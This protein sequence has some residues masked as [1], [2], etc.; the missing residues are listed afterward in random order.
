MFP[1]YYLW[2]QPTRYVRD[3]ATPRPH[4][5]VTTFTNFAQ[6]THLLALYGSIMLYSSTMWIFWTIFSAWYV[7]LLGKKY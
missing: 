6:K 7:G 1:L 4:C 2:F 3:V 5:N